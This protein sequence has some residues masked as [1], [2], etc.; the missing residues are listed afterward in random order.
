MPDIGQ[1]YLSMIAAI[2][3]GL[4]VGLERGWTQRELGKGRRVAGFRTFGLIGLLG[5]MGG[6]APDII[7]ATLGARS[8]SSLPSAISAAPIRIICRPRQRWRAS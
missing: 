2:A 1:P 7:A 4:L 5:G 8:S 3:I 6:L